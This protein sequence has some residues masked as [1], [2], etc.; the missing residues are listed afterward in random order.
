MMFR[1]ISTLKFGHVAIICGLSGAVLALS[2][3]NFSLWY[4]AWIGIVP[5][6]VIV[7]FFEEKLSFKKTAI[8]GFVFGFFHFLVGLYWI[9]I[10]LEKY[11]GLPVWLSIPVLILLCGY[12]AFYGLAFAVGI[13]VFHKNIIPSWL[14]LPSLWVVLEW[15]RGKLITGFPWN[16]LAYSQTDLKWLRQ[17]ADITGA[18]GVSWMIVLTNALIARALI[19]KR[20]FSGWI[21]LL[22]FMIASWWYGNSVLSSNILCK[23]S[24]FKVAIVQGNIDQAQKWDEAFR[25]MTIQTYANLSFD[26]VR[27]GNVDLVVWPE[28]AMPFVYGFIPDLTMRVDGIIDQLEVPVLFG[29]I[30][31]TGM[32]KDARFLNKAYLVEPGGSISGDYAKEHLVP[33]GEYVPLQKI[34][35][36]V[37][38]LVP[39]AGDFVPGR[40]SG[41]ISW[42][43]ES[44]GMLICYEV[45]FPELARK[46]VLNG[47]TLFVNISNDAWFGKS[48]APYQHLESARWRAIETKRAIVRATNTGVSAFIDPFGDISSSLGL[49]K[50]GT[51]VDSVKTC[52]GKTFYVRYGDVFVLLCAL[53]ILAATLYFINE[54][55]KKQRGNGL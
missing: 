5:L 30:G 3:P 44:I 31:M 51:L 13:K 2:F 18:Y 28:S 26:A 25:D 53:I 12:L 38:K 35:F 23:E 55:L 54:R 37:H 15:I 49:F 19:K 9:D 40:S 16:L 29:T 6:I 47:A 21:V 10:V 34:L 24:G 7:S 4:L 46:R 42:R 50:A 48:S 36:F 33:F 39:T 8:A 22:M 32:T 45:I 43:G 27:S 20:D 41:V 1:W 14:I 17:V 11:G 52:T